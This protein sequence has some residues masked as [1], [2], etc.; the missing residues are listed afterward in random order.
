MTGN[1]VRELLKWLL[2]KPTRNVVWDWYETT[3]T[4]RLQ[5]LGFMLSFFSGKVATN[6][7]KH[8]R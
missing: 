4:L 8:G 2:R 5:Y 1:A 6:N 3:H 7:V